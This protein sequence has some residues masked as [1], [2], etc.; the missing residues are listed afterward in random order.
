MVTCTRLPIKRLRTY[1]FASAAHGSSAWFVLLQTRT[2]KSHEMSFVCDQQRIR[3]SKS[4]NTAWLVTVDCRFW[5]RGCLQV[6][7]VFPPSC[8]PN[9]DRTSTRLNSSH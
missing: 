1:S 5:E 4:T 2:K 3:E 6:R 9:A 8:H 7:D